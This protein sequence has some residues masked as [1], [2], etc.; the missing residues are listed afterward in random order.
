MYAV[1]VSRDVK[2][3]VLRFSR[4]SIMS[5]RS[6]SGVFCHSRYMI[7]AGTARKRGNPGEMVG[8]SGDPDGSVA[9]SWAYQPALDGVRALAVTAVV[10]FHAGVPGFSGGYLGVDTFF[11]LSGF[12]ITSL[13][14]AER[15]RYGRIALRAFWLRRARRLLP[16]LLIML[17]VVVLTARFLQTAD[18]FRLLR[19]DA[20]ASLGYVANW[21]MIWRGSDY[22]TATSD[23]SLVQHAWSLGIEEQF[24]ALW[25]LIVAGI[26]L[27]WAARR[28][29]LILL[30][31]CVAGALASAVAAAVLFRPD[32]VNRAYFG[33]DSR[34][35]ALL[36]GAALAVALDLRPIGRHRVIAGAAVFGAVTTGVLWFLTGTPSRALFSGGL[37]VAAL[38][39]AAVLLHITTNQESRFAR[40]LSIRPLVWL[41]TVSYGVY[42]WHWPVFGFMTAG[43]TGLAGLG[44]LVARLGM[45]VALTVASYYA[46]EVPIRRGLR[47]PRPVAVG[48]A[49]G[50]CALSVSLVAF[51]SPRQLPSIGAAPPVVIA[52]SAS[53]GSGRAAAPVDRP[54]RKPGAQPRVTFLGD[55]VA[56][57]IGSYLPEH[58]GLWTGNRAIEGCGIATL[59]DILQQGTPHTNYPGCTKWYQR[60][61]RGV[62]ADDP[63]VA[64][65]LLNRW[66]LMDRRLDGVYQ[67]VGQP[68][69]DAYLKKQLDQAVKIAGGRGATVVLLSAAYTHRTERPDGGLYDEDQ[70]DR[71]NAWNRLLAA[72]QADPPH[73]VVL[74]DLNAVVCPAG[75]FTWSIGNVQVRSDGLHFTPEGVQRIIAPWL[76]PRLA[77]IAHG[78]E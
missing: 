51:A 74:L 54:G 11:V 66:E 39:T 25:P 50:A 1:D 22:F 10:L 71:V 52:A 6:H 59:P 60:W 32:D 48:S 20:L 41:G 77:A 24:Y 47:W 16:A 62:Q 31:G 70:P 30:L 78:Q 19:L 53:T 8:G 38:A 76:L 2:G 43:R 64:V 3:R 75:R 49:V 42:L 13:L 17:V 57:T 4:V 46:V 35:Q 12:L 61:E 29:R 69:Y 7:D 21:R 34:A 26:A 44:L 5:L 63:D 14:L 73:R 67:H 37:T 27:V 68:A 58:P 9:P 15:A 18:E 33:T 72:E 45:T 36:I 55:S 23:P 65:I 28:W 56:W 40:V